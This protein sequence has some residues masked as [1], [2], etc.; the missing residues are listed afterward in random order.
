MGGGYSPQREGMAAVAH[1]IRGLKTDLMALNRRIS[2]LGI[3]VDKADG[4]LIIAAGRSLVVNGDTL[5]EGNLS[6]PNGSI[7]N[8]GLQNPAAATSWRGELDNLTLPTSLTYYFAHTM[9][10]PSSRYTTAAL[11]LIGM[12]QAAWGS[13]TGVGD[14]SVTPSAT[15]GSQS[16]T[17]GFL[18]A[19]S[20]T[21]NYANVSIEATVAGVFTNVPTSG[22]T[23]SLGAEVSGGFAASS[24][25]LS[26]AASVIWLP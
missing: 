7:T 25:S 3:Q 6:V 16:L 22:F 19:Q 23:V 17:L 4:K 26:L 1:I 8:A 10:P 13:A 2:G 9:A 12:G 15:N 11:T 24:G 18:P 21:G 14:L 20:A 5:I